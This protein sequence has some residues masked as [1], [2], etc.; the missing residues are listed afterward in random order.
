[1]YSFAKWN[2]HK[3]TVLFVCV[4]YTT[5]TN[6]DWACIVYS[7]CHI[8]STDYKLQWFSH[9]SREFQAL[10]D[11]WSL[12]QINSPGG[13][14][15]WNFFVGVYVYQITIS[16]NLVISTL[17]RLDIGDGKELDLKECPRS[18]L[19]KERIKYLGPVC[20]SIN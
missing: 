18:K 11:C 17:C 16:I 4:I 1:M 12:F 10:N 15:C 9:Q 3:I 13:I 20:P 14:R 7:L 6:N 2:W 8:W 5:R 19:H